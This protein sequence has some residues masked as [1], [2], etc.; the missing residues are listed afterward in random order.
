MRLSASPL[1]PL[2]E[3]PYRA[4]MCLSLPACQ[5]LHL[6]AGMQAPLPALHGPDLSSTPASRPLPRPLGFWLRVA[7]PGLHKG[8]EDKGGV[9]GRGGRKFYSQLPQ[10]LDFPS[11]T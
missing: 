5:G 1:L 8:R 2:E 4:K 9:Q 6:A 3:F 10:D 11:G 7:A